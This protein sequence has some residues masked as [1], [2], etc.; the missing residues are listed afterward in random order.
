VRK[1][2]KLLKLR[3][4]NIRGFDAVDQQ[5]ADRERSKGRP[6]MCSYAGSHTQGRGRRETRPASRAGEGRRCLS[7]T[8]W[9]KSH[10]LLLSGQPSSQT[11][12]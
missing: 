9:E 11:D 4:D 6:E 8:R 5:C 1:L 10:N 7:L 3:V 12:V 2:R